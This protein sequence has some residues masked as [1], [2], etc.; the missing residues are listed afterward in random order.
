M[1]DVLDVPESRGV[2]TLDRRLDAEREDDR[3]TG[4]ALDSLQQPFDHGLP[5]LR[6]AVHR[7][8]RRGLGR[9]YST[10]FLGGRGRLQ[11]QEEEHTGEGHGNPFTKQIG[12]T[13]RD[14]KSYPDKPTEGRSR[15]RTRVGAGE[16][17]VYPNEPL[18]LASP[19]H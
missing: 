13:Q 7:A 4:R 15:A 6:R 5:L 17:P 16:H 11:Q 8:D 3:P 9:I 18:R 14:H 19:M 10:G 12:R 1:G 2:E